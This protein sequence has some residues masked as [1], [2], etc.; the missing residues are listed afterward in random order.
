MVHSKLISA[1]EIL[2]QYSSQIDDFTNN[3]DA[4]EYLIDTIDYLTLGKIPCNYEVLSVI[5][6]DILV[7][8]SYHKSNE[9]T[10]VAVL[11]SDVIKE[12]EICTK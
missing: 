2:V 12:V 1:K 5:L 6:E 9:L 11:I 8:N 10:K 3:Y 4:I 7:T